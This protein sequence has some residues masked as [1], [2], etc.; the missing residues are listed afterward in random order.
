MQYIVLSYYLIIYSCYFLLQAGLFDRAR[1]MLMMAKVMFT[2][3][4]VVKQLEQEEI[5]E[6]DYLKQVMDALKQRVQD[7]IEESKSSS[8]SEDD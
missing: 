6:T 2:D 4:V 8:S 7:G 3:L 5:E 1:A